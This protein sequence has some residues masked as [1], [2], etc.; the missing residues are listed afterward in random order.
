KSEISPI[1]AELTEAVGTAVFHGYDAT[2]VEEAEI[3]AIIKRDTRVD[4]LAEGEEGIV[5]LR[6][7][8]FYAEA[9]GQ[10]GDTGVLFNTDA[11]LKVIDT[12]APLP[13]LI[14]HKSRVESGTVK[15]GD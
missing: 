12:F 14:L 10:V 9:G 6:E 4:E 8:P 13:G 1:Y 15:V 5:I 2:R 3:A 11:Q 7:T